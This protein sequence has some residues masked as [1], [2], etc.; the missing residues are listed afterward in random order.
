MNSYTE[1]GHQLNTYFTKYIITSAGLIT[2]LLS[3]ESHIDIRLL[4]KGTPGRRCRQRDV[5]EYSSLY[6]AN[7]PTCPVFILYVQVKENIHVG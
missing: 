5:K 6:H 2:T 4:M 3:P 7:M 1:S